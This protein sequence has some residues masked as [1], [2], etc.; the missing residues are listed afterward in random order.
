MWDGEDDSAA[1]VAMSK[2]ELS[3]V[4][5]KVLNASLSEEYVI[6]IYPASMGLCRFQ[7]DKDNPPDHGWVGLP[8]LPC[9]PGAPVSRGQ[10]SL[11]A[12]DATHGPA[13]ALLRRVAHLA[14]LPRREGARSVICAVLAG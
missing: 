14:L 3:E 12:A 1:Y 8:V 5:V 10:E 13:G 2:A 4:L 11:C 6:S 9:P 7:L